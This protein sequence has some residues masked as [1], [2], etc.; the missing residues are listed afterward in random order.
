ML[1]HPS[2]LAT[3]LEFSCLDTFL[4]APFTWLRALFTSDPHA[5]SLRPCPYSIKQISADASHSTWNLRSIP[6]ISRSTIGRSLTEHRLK[7][8]DLR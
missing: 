3:Y 8:H 2:T 5:G 4:E 7:I 1:D 6:K